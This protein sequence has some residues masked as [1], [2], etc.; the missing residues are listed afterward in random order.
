LTA[1]G[2]AL[3][4]EEVALPVELALAARGE[5]EEKADQR[6]ISP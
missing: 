5:S 3:L 2:A 6:R 1:T 4:G